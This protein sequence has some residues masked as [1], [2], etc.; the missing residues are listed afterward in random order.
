M[1]KPTLTLDGRAFDTLA[2]FFAEAGRVLAPGAGWGHNLDAFE[3]V[4]RGGFG[5]P[6]GGFTLVWADAEVSRARLGYP[7]TVRQLD[8]RLAAC[9]PSNR[10]AVAAELAAARAGTGPTVFDWLVALIGRHRA[11]GVELVLA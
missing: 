10:P 2:G 9:H 3:D 1:P 6:A 7:E 11:D 4:L 8:A 5:T